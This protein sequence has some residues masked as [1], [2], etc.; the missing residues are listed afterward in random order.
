MTQGNRY[1]CTLSIHCKYYALQYI[2]VIC[3]MIKYGC[4]QLG[5]VIFAIK[6]LR[7]S[8]IALDPH[9]VFKHIPNR[10]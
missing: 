3:I 9:L 7:I 2:E 5:V 8:E 1:T 4:G 10:N 6:I